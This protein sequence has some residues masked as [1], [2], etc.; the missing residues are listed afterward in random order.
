MNIWM[1]GDWVLDGGLVGVG[2]M[3][4]MYLM[5]GRWVLDKWQVSW[6]V[7]GCQMVGG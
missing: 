6:M 1:D 3:V 4:G 7:H 2:Q 5:D